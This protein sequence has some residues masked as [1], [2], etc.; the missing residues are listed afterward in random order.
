MGGMS[1]R[2]RFARRF[3]HN[4]V[5][6]AGATFVV[7]LVLVAI[8]APPVA[9]YDPHVA[10]GGLRTAFL[11]PSR[12]HWL[13]TDVTGLDQFSRVVYGTRLALLAGLEAVF[14]SLAIGLP[15]GLSIGYSGCG[16][17]RFSMRGGDATVAV[18]TTMRAMAIIA[19]TGPG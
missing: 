5:A 17:D 9:P 8:F 19:A 16:T 13:G 6:M 10:T 15:I 1:G 14:V 11:P 2:K 3:L 12:D 7:I 4:R 18:P